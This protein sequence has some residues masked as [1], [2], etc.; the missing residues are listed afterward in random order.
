VDRPREATQLEELEWLFEGAERHTD[1]SFLVMP[2]MENSNLLGGH[3]DLLF[4]HPVYYV[5]GRQPG[6]P[7]VTQHPEY[8]RVYN[9][10]TVDDMIA[11][12]EAEDML[13]FM[14]HPRTK[15]STGYPDAIRQSRQFQT[16]WYRG[17]GWRWGMGSDLSEAR[18]SDKRVIPL[19]DDMN[20][21][22]ARSNLRPKGLLAITET[23][24]KQPGDDVYAN[25]PVTYL[26][27]GELPEPG[28]YAPIVDA[29]D[30]GDYFVTSGEVLIPS[31]R[32]EGT[33]ANMRVVAD[34]QWTFPLEF[35]EV[36]FGDGTNTTTRTMSATDLP[37]FGRQTFTIPFD[38]TGQA[39]VRFA[40]WD[41]AGN[42][43]MSTPV[44]LGTP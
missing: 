9:I 34:V 33:G 10:G 36:V 5:D 11:M 38:S 39:W 26:R 22:I 31:V 32:Y 23:Y 8:G 43:A 17:V 14:P 28:N 19:L 20:N 6:T 7:L 40:A 41:S 13:V 3:W 30:R 18:L 12:I 35:V 37:A 42:G 29:L 21:W 2:Q 25:G 16:D 44:R 27:L 1:D 15:G 4:S 24:A